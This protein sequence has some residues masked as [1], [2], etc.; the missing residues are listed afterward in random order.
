MSRTLSVSLI[1]TIL[2]LSVTAHAA[3]PLQTR[4]DRYGDPLPPGAVARLGTLR[5]RVS[6]SQALGLAFTG[7]G[8]QIVSATE[9]GAVEVFDAKTGRRVRRI[10]VDFHPRGFA[11]SP[12]GKHAA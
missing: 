8:T 9:T 2:G 10:P 5:Y 7:D 1:S 3:A 11:L 6:S 12:D 4:H